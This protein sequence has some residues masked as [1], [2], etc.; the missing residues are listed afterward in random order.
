M[1]NLVAHFKKK[2]H[3]RLKKR[4]LWVMRLVGYVSGGGNADAFGYPLPE[5]GRSDYLHVSSVA[6]DQ[7]FQLVVDHYVEGDL[8][9]SVGETLLHFLRLVEWF[10]L[11]IGCLLP[12]DLDHHA[13]SLVVYTFGHSD[14]IFEEMLGIEINTFLKGMFPVYLHRMNTVECEYV[15]LGRPVGRFLTNQEPS[16][17]VFLQKIR[18]YCYLIRSSCLERL[19]LYQ[20]GLPLTHSII[21][22]SDELSSAIARD[23][24]HVHRRYGRACLA[25]D[26]LV[27]LT[28]YFDGGS[29]LGKHLKLAQYIQSRVEGIESFLVQR[30]MSD[31]EIGILILVIFVFPDYNRGIISEA[32]AA[33]ESQIVL[34]CPT[35]YG[36]RPPLVFRKRVGAGVNKVV[37][38][39]AAIPILETPVDGRDPYQ[40]SAVEWHGF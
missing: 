25:G 35:A 4:K 30:Q 26:L 32:V 18:I 15:D 16:I 36:S 3:F 22:F 39:P 24:L 20:E 11:H 34:E 37:D 13:L 38:G 31:A 10:R 33:H 29:E 23:M 6:Q 21:D 1:R 8:Y 40:C 5:S 9:A 14:G 27:E 17:A 19:I 28:Y 12:V 7:A 2:F